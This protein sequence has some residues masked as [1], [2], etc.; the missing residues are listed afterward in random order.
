MTKLVQVLL[1]DDYEVNLELL[2]A[3]LTLSEIPMRIF[4]AS[5]GAEAYQCINQNKLDL[6]LLDVMLPDTSGYEI[7]RML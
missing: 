3:Y 2:E 1:V 6:I 4:K 7:C 5:N